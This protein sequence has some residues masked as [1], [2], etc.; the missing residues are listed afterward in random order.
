VDVGFERLGRS[1]DLAQVGKAA[2]RETGGQ[3][4]AR[5]GPEAPCA[6]DLAHKG[7]PRRLTPLD[8]PRRRPCARS[9]RNW[10]VLH[11]RTRVEQIFFL[12]VS[13]TMQDAHS[14]RR[15]RLVTPT[16]LAAAAA[17]AAALTAALALVGQS[18]A[19]SFA[20]A[21]V[22]GGSALMAAQPETSPFPCEG[23]EYCNVG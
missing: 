4:R 14:S 2:V 1:P 21:R 20:A 5:P 16:R 9:G 3:I 8:Q 12:G 22:S 7:A 18:A 11:E 10:A 6:P 19:S 17:A 15:T 23:P 13:F